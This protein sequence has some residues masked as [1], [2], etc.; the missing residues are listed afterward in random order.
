[1]SAFEG[2][3][4]IDLSVDEPLPT[5]TPP[6]L[7]HIPSDQENQETRKFL[8]KFSQQLRFNAIKDALIQLFA[9]L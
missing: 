9:N 6:G 7:Y 1:M 8:F 5:D 4:R 2:M 3:E